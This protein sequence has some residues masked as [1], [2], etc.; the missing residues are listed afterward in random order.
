MMTF[1]FYKLYFKIICYLVF[2][3]RVIIIEILKGLLL[4]I[5]LLHHN[6][7]HHRY[8]SISLVGKNKLKLNVD[9]ILNF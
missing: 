8:L 7:I 2:Y 4:C 3:E 9:M 6:W 1:H 5:I